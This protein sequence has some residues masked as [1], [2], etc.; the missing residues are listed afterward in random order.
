[1]EIVSVET[2]AQ[3]S[4]EG[5]TVTVSVQGG[6]PTYTYFLFDASGE[7]VQGTSSEDTT[8]TFLTSG[9]SLG[10]GTYAVEVKDLDGTVVRAD[11]VI[12]N[13]FTNELTNYIALNAKYCSIQPE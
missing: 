3:N 9:E 10:F 4:P 6:R 5:G 8:F 11:N 1:L 7:L 13:L 2:T 12:V